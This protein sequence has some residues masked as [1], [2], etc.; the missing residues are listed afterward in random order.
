V[1]SYTALIFLPLTTSAVVNPV[2]DI[3]VF[4]G[5][6]L[7]LTP[8]VGAIHPG[9]LDLA[10]SL[11][12]KARRKGIFIKCEESGVLLDFSQRGRITAVL[13]TEIFLVIL[14]LAFVY[15]DS[16]NMHGTTTTLTATT[17]SR[18]TATTTAT[19]TTTATATTI[20]TTTTMIATTTTTTMTTTL[21]MKPI[22]YVAPLYSYP[23]EGAATP[24]FANLISL[25]Q[26]YPSVPI[27]AVVNNGNGAG[28]FTDS[29]LA[30]AIAAMR[31][32]GIVVIGYVYVVQGGTAAAR[33]LTG[34]DTVV[35][36]NDQNRGLEQAIDAWHTNYQLDGL[37]FD[38]AIIG[39]VPPFPPP[40]QSSSPAPGW[41]GHTILQYFQA[42][43]AYARSDGYGFLMGNVGPGGVYP[44]MA[45]LW[46]SMSLEAGTSQSSLWTT[47]QLS[48]WTASVAS[49]YTVIEYNITPV[50]S[51]AYLSSIEPYVSYVAYTDASGQPSTSFQN[52]LLANL[53]QL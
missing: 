22:G 52:A 2:G 39:N 17:T 21:V 7:T 16:M 8:L 47:T 46:D 28:A 5:V 1:A 32:V 13:A 12:G 30:S 31:A 4:L 11:S 15:Q 6:H 29:N 26:Q 36:A 35:G 50:P 53:N 44:E 10:V 49:E 27:V 38:N 34:A 43:T 37:F 24:A 20:A 19:T 48:A 42:A 40:D 9:D 25:K 14:I 18:T 41:P 3:V 33:N 45:G 23:T 51:V